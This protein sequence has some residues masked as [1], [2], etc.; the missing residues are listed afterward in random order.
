MKT[1][2]AGFTLVEVIA[3]LL[4]VGILGAIAGMGIVTGMRGYMQ[5][6]ENA[7]LVQKAQVSMSRIGRELMELTDII[8]RD[9]GS[10]PWVIFDN[11]IG[12]Q[13]LAKVGDTLQ[14]YSLPAG[15]GDLS[16][17]TGDIIVDQVDSLTFTYHSGT[18]PTW[19]ISDGIDML[20]AVEV[21]VNLLRTEA[22]GA[23]Q[24]FSI[25]VNPRNTKNF[26]GASANVE[27]YTAPQ[28]QC[29]IATAASAD[30]VT[31]YGYLLPLLALAAM[32]GLF[33][34]IR[35]IPHRGRSFPRGKRSGTTHRLGRAGGIESLTNQKGNVLV[36]LVVTMLLFAALGAGMVTM[37]GT[38]STSQ[39][40]GN[41]AVRAYY[42]AESGFRY[43]A[44]QYLNTNDGNN[45][46][47]SRDEKNQILQTLDN[48][49]YTLAND[50]GSFRL[51][52]FPYYFSVLA[53]ANANATSLYTRF[54]GSQPTGFTLPP[55]GIIARIKIGQMV[56]TYGSYNSGTGQFTSIAPPLPENVYQNA[57]VKLVG[58]PS[59]SAVVAQGGDLTLATASFFP[60][61]QGRVKINGVAYGYT[62]CDYNTNTLQDLY[63]V[64]DPSASFNIAVDSTTDVVLDPYIQV[65]SIGTVSSGD[66]AATREVVYNTPL[67]EKP[68]TLEAVEFRDE[69]TDLSAWNTPTYGSFAIETV[70]G[71]NVLA[72]TGV[73]PG[74][75]ILKA[76]LIGFNWTSTP[77][78]FASTHRTAGYYLSYD[79]QV[80]IGFDTVPFPETGWGPEGSPIPKHFAAGLSFRLDENQNAYGLSFM[81]GCRDSSVIDCD[82]P[83]RIDNPIVPEDD[84][85]MVVLWQ[86]TGDGSTRQWLAYSEVGLLFSEGAELEPP[87]GK[88]TADD[89]HPGDPLWVRADNYAYS[90]IYSWSTSPT[91]TYTDPPAGQTWNDSLTSATIDLSNANSA[92]LTFMTR[93]R[94]YSCEDNGFV[95]ISGD[96]GSSW[97]PLN[98][99]IS[100]H[101][102]GSEPNDSSEARY[103]SNSEDLPDDLNGWV[104]KSLNIS[105]YAGNPNV[106]IRFRFERNPSNT[107]DGWW[108]DDIRVIQDFDIND[109]TLLVRI[110]EA[111]LVEFDSGG[112]TV[113]PDTIDIDAGDIVYQSSGASGRVIVPP[114]LA[115]GSWAGGS[116]AGMVW[117]NNTTGPAF[118]DALPLSVLKPS[119]SNLAN[120]T[121][122][123]ARRNFIQAYYGAQNGVSPP[124]SADLAGLY[125]YDQQ[126]L[127]NLFGTAN[128]PPNPIYLSP[129]DPPFSGTNDYFT[130]VQWNDA[131][132]GA[133][134]MA[135]ENGEYTII[136]S[137]QADLFTPIDTYIPYTRPELGLHA[138]GHGAENAYF[139]D[140]AVRAGLAV[141]SGLIPIQQ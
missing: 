83:D 99:N 81:R 3:S 109:A 135:D 63:L 74:F 62:S 122:T 30:T 52:I 127:S 9:D 80:K 33:N 37:T 84:V 139:K 108:L 75:G 27:P 77:I 132:Q 115:S 51:R 41:T 97:I 2:N 54:P 94:I 31:I 82:P 130:L 56:H 76:S 95:E 126:R 47:E 141:Q 14:L 68:G 10:D 104:K 24:P 71:E 66:L 46:Y 12:R 8:A 36:G 103:T 18:D 72:V 32:A 112:R 16:G 73:E 79:S 131:V 4:I 49:T 60:Q 120:V 107:R 136:A 86:Q 35:F 48:R 59:G 87:P 134:R 58:I 89:D 78:N 106:R 38:S 11:P 1:P 123:A 25:T 85:K 70:G 100:Q 137:N 22:G 20:S 138:I 118:S 133:T 91:D 98:D 116:A 92:A 117:L 124:T 128:W 110:Y 140:F 93:Y 34:M 102:G 21:D 121:N 13:A 88:W 90:G 50:D 42:V 43:A 96:G 23:T 57:T 39:V 28:Y 55:A 26:S 64:D 67:P 125:Q 105:S 6:K 5:T 111:A 29:F 44:S 129:P 17:F 114:I 53:D 19:V 45:R 101:C 15:A 119:G 61:L 113:G 65:R 69:F 7:H 40:I